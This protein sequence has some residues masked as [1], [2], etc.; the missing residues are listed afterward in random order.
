[1]LLLLLATNL[2][3]EQKPLEGK[4]CYDAFSKYDP[5]FVVDFANRA[6][7]HLLKHGDAAFVDFNKVG[8]YTFD[9][10]PY[11]P[12]ITVLRCDEMRAAS[13]FIDEMR[14]QM[15]TPGALKKFVDANGKHTFSNLCSKVRGKVQAA[16]VMQT[17]Y[18]IS[19]TSPLKMGVYI[20]KVPGT[21][22]VIQ[23]S[24]PSLKY[25]LKDFEA[26]LK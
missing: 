16:W 8:P 1:M 2:W 9:S 7:E 25:K 13:F 20:V 5:K 23:S 3:A 10:F 14:P 19:C 26:S 15:T 12:P 4:S 17:H 22:Y 6:K 18:W 21:P 11:S 24:L